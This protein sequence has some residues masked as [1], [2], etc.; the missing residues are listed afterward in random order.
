M[1]TAP[2]A[3]QHDRISAVLVLAIT[4]LLYFKNSYIIK[5]IL[6]SMTTYDIEPR[7]N[8][9]DMVLTFSRSIPRPLNR[10]TT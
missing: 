2:L 10:L 3:K 9:L 8:S 7:E 5:M 4:Y 1:S 6:S